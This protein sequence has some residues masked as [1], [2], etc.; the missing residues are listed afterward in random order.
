MSFPF[1]LIKF[2]RNEHRHDVLADRMHVVA[3]NAN[4]RDVLGGALV[5]HALAIELGSDRLEAQTLVAR[6]CSQIAHVVKNDPLVRPEPVRLATL[7]APWR[8]LW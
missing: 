3:F 1:V 6:A 5:R 7:D 8:Q 4:L 2:P